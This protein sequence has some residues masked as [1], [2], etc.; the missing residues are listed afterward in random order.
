[1]KKPKTHLRIL[2]CDLDGTLADEGQVAPETWEKLF[3]AKASGLSIIVVTGRRLET[4]DTKGLFAEVCDA[5]VAEDGAAIY[6]PQRDTVVLPFGRLD[7]LLLQHLEELSLPLEYGMAIVATHVPHDLPIL[8]LLRDVGGGAV[9]EYNRGAVMVLPDG[10]TKGTGLQYALNELGYSAHNVVACG[11]AENDRSLFAVAELSVAVANA[12]PDIKTLV[13][14]V[15]PY[16]NAAG[17]CWLIDNLLAGEIPPHQ[18]SPDR[19]LLLGHSIEKVPFYMDPFTLLNGNLGVFGAST[20]GK[21]WIAGFLSEQLLKQGY[22][23]CLIDPE[24]DYV[25]LRAFPH[26]LLLG[27]PDIHLPAIAE[28][29]TLSEYSNLSLVLNLCTYS[30]EERRDYVTRLLQALQGLR[31]RRGQPHWLLIDEIHSFC[32]PEYSEL[33]ERCLDL[34]EEGGVGVVSY[35]PSLVNP[36]ILTKLNQW[37]LTRTRLS[38]EICELERYLPKSKDKSAILPLLP[39]LPQ[40][41]ACLLS[42]AHDPTMQNDCRIVFQAGARRI[43]H[44]RHLHKYLKAPLPR[45]KQFYFCNT[46]GHFLGRT[47]ASLFEFSEAI[48]KV[49]IQ[50][51]EYHLAREDFEHWLRKVLYEE[52]LSRRL[53]KIARRGL[54]GE[55]LRHAMV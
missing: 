35:R 26:T 31:S 16:P 34:M 36:A 52:E 9:V 8:D 17:V 47:A 23:I 45:E 42:S 55:E 2:A 41:Q 50:S 15:A 49:P 6:F 3:Q 14:V 27:G 28:V 44:I 30:V 22:Q 18:P 21:S 19:A 13:D 11:N 32:P 10:A 38:D 46:A 48:K 24:G 54:H 4:F 40:G 53:R 5:I 12:A 29:L 25:N 37:L 33:T 43:P 20:S 7:P 51:L 1:M 39:T